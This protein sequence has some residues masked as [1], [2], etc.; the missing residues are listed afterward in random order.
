MDSYFG[1]VVKV[2]AGETNLVG[3]CN[4]PCMAKAEKALRIYERKRSAIT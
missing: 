2:P 1:L 3:V 4:I